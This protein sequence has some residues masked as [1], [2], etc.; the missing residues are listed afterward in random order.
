MVKKGIKQLITEYRDALSEK[1]PV[2]KIYLFGSYAINSQKIDS[3]IDVAV[4]LSKEI[5]YNDELEAMRLR[6][7]IDL[8]IEPHL[9][10]TDD[11]KIPSPII[12]EILKNGIRI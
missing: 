1:F 8:R 10:S 4:V 3:D 5:E 9:F 12:T 7:N 11:F 6:R 2:E